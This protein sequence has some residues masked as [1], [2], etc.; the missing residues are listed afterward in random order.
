M[1]SSAPAI[2]CDIAE[3]LLRAQDQTDSRA[4]VFDGDGTLWQGDASEDVFQFA[5]K[6]RMLRE[7]PLQALRDVA[8]QYDLADDGDSNQVADTLFQAYLAGKVPED[9]VCEMMCWCYAGFTEGQLDDLIV[10]ALEAASFS[11]RRQDALAPILAQASAQ[12]WRCVVV[13]AS[14]LAIVRQAVRASW[15]LAPSDILACRPQLT[16]GPLQPQLDTPLLYGP[17]KVSACAKHLASSEWLGGFGDNIFDSEMLQRA[18]V[19]VAVFPKQAL[20][21]C[22]NKLDPIFVI[23]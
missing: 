13:S 4:L 8:S 17:T 1:T 22:L 10:A 12:G 6:N 14:P 9:L 21:L 2:V 18:V 16:D 19:K 5:T 3:A 7:L 20:K 15:Q 11:T 23:E